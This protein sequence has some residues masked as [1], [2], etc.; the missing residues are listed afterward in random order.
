MTSEIKV[1]VSIGMGSRYDWP[2]GKPISSEPLADGR[3]LHLLEDGRTITVKDPMYRLDYQSSRFGAEPG[4]TYP[5]N[6]ALIGL[7]SVAGFYEV[8]NF[9]KQEVRSYSFAKTVRLTDLESDEVYS[10]D[11]LKEHYGVK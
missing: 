2:N 3:V 9:D 1:T 11:E 10:V 8:W 6:I 5:V 4:D 7:S